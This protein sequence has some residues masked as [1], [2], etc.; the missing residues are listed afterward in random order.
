MRPCDPSARI[1][2]N[3]FPLLSET[4]F[5]KYVDHSVADAA[6][7]LPLARP[8]GSLAGRRA[9]FRMACR[10][11]PPLRVAWVGRGLLGACGTRKPTVS[12]G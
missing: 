11:R 9:I 7:R 6:P 12:T 4:H 3:M 2:G 1:L 8:V 10:Q 5:A